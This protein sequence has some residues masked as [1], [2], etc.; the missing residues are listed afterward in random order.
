MAQ[1]GQWLRI[2]TETVVAPG[3]VVCAHVGGRKVALFNQDG[4]YRAYDDYCTH[5][6]GPLT[7][8]TCEDGIVTC[9]WHGAQFRVSDGA[10]LRP[11]AGGRLRAYPVRLVDGVIEV[12]FDE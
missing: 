11:P 2:G 3:K 5:N 6:G 1:V 7:Q 10:P 9:L 4:V 12:E 8:G